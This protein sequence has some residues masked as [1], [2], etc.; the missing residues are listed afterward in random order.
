M[1]GHKKINETIQNIDLY[2]DKLDECVLAFK[3]G[4]KN[5]LEGSRDA[6]AENLKTI[7]SL[8]NS[9]TEI[10]RTIENELYTRSIILDNRVEILQLLDRLDRIINKLYK[11]LHQYEDEIPFFPAELSIDYLKLVEVSALSV[12]GLV[13]AMKDY[14]RMPRFVADKVHRIYYFE[15]EVSRL[16]QS[17]K[18]HVFHDMD[19]VK[20]SQKIHIRYF[21]LHVEE[22]AEESMKAADMLS[23]AVLRQTI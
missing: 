1:F 7:T 22:L 6:F 14:F 23:I 11:Y 19:S 16:A 18:H 17:I 21:T 4:V 9:T 20:L 5:Y 15:K 12:E 10:R 13:S 3:S 8:R 2:L